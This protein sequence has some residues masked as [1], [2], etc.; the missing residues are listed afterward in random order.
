MSRVIKLCNKH[1]IPLHITPTITCSQTEELFN[2]FHADL[3]LSLGNGYIGKRI[4]SIP[5]FGMINI[6][7]EELPKYQ[8][9]QSIIWQLYNNSRN[10]G[11]TIHKIDNHIDTGEIIFKE[12]IP[13]DLK[14]NLGL[15]VSY[16]LS[17]LLKKSSKSLIKILENY[18]TFSKNSTPQEDGNSYTTPSLIQYLRMLKNFRKMKRTQKLNNG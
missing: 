4:F 2:K 1:N 8:N 13:I 7:H 5:K 3:G 9:A 6:H 15:T 10:T 12:I 14:E 18:E 11:Y 16:N 17:K